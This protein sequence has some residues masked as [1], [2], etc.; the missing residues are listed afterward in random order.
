MF[1]PEPEPEEEEE[2]EGINDPNFHWQGV[3]LDDGTGRDVYYVKRDGSMR[4]RKKPHG[5]CEEYLDN[6]E[7]MYYYR[8]ACIRCRKWHQEPIFLSYGSGSSAFSV[9]YCE[10]CLIVTTPGLTRLRGNGALIWETNVDTPKNA[11]FDLKK[12]CMM[13][14]R[15]EKIHKRA[16][17]ARHQVRVDMKMI[18]NRQ[19]TLA[20]RELALSYECDVREGIHLS[21]GFEDVY[22]EY[23]GTVNTN[24][25]SGELQPHGYGV[26]LYSDGTVYFGSWVNGEY[27]TGPM[28]RSG[29]YYEDVKGNL[30]KPTGAE[31][32]GQWYQ[33]M[34]HGQGV[35]LYPDGSKYEGEFAK[36]FEHGQGKKNYANNTSFE[37]RFRF[38]RKDG[39]GTMTDAD[40]TATKG[41]FLD[42]TEKYNEKIPP[43]IKEE[44]NP[45]EEYHHPLSLR[46]LSLQ[47]LA[48]AMHHNRKVYGPASKLQ[49]MVPEHM[50]YL[51]GQEYLRIMDPKGSPSFMQIG[52][53]FAF[54]FLDE[55]VFK[56][57][58]IIEADAQALMY[59]QN[60]N[61]ELK[62]LKC[63]ANKMNLSSIDLIC[64]N[65]Q[66]HAWP[67]LYVLDLSFN[68][69]DV[70][71]LAA[72]MSG[73]SK[74]DTLR[75]L[76][77]RACGIRAQGANVI[78]QSLKND[79]QVEKLDL[80]FNNLELVGSEV[81]AEMLLI[82]TNIREL[83]LRSNGIGALGAQAIA[84]SLSVNKTLMVL[85]MADNG[86]GPDLIA[87]LSG[88]LNGTFRDVLTSSRNKEVNMPPHYRLGR[89]DR[90]KVAKNVVIK[91][92]SDND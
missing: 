68:L 1:A 33:G 15:D 89:Y 6:G 86:V 18:R 90:K 63:T 17:E 2:E 55:V 22:D 7:R 11:W 83:N 57:V 32:T 51:L 56:S 3:C 27:H 91:E 46:E 88:K 37:G 65:L 36:G 78:S 82:N 80:A 87:V 64:K 35:Q 8:K 47:S 41:T 44:L 28:W 16:V 10:E 34:K 66:A 12:I 31:Y 62:V 20:I 77:L 84:N 5:Y 74:I 61:L 59:F 40:G 79:K 81:M 39:P 30:I 69:F 49:R 38:G 92:D 13:P 60:S 73:I 71:A 53:E 21:W 54:N 4:Q 42:P 67:Q 29:T 76:S 25:A 9:N 70:S 50:K 26:R 45:L 24:S 52:P 85:V 58:K 19:R 14:D 23:F 43:F 72:L 75:T 48:W